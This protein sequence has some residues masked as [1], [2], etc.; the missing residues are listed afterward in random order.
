MNEIIALIGL[1]AVETQQKANEKETEN[2]MKVRLIR[3]TMAS[4]LQ[5]I[6]KTLE[7][8]WGISGGGTADVPPVLARAYPVRRVL[9]NREDI[10]YSRRM[11]RGRGITFTDAGVRLPN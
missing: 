9:F 8:I 6:A 2:R 5:G 11:G 3:F 4:Y 1:S 10:H 7:G